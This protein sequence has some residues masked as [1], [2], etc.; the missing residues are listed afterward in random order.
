LTELV[1]NV[2]DRHQWRKIVHDAANPHS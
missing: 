1:M 2:E